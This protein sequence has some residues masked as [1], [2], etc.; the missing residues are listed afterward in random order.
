MSSKSGSSGSLA[1]RL[2]VWYTASAFA[3]VLAASGFLYWALVDNLEREDA[4]VLADQVEVLRILLRE[5]PGDLRVLKQ[6]VE[7]ETVGRQ[8]PRLLL[9]IQGPDGRVLTETPGMARELPP[10]VFPSPAEGRVA[11]R[12]AASGTSFELLAAHAE[13]YVIQVALDA[14][15]EQQLLA[16][17]R[18][19][20][21]PILAAAL[22]LSALVGH[23]IARRGIRPVEEI[24]ETARGIRS[25]TLNERIALEHLP[26]ELVS[27]AA[28][29]NGMLARLEEAFARLSRFS[30]D[31]A[32]EL[33]TP[34]N[35]L[36]GEAE[37]ALGRPR[38]PEEYREVLGSSLEE[39]A[40]LSRLIDSLLFL[41]RAEDPGTQI[42][43]ERVDLAGELSSLCAFYEA[44]AGEKGVTLKSHATEGLS[45]GLDRTLFQRAAGNLIENALAHSSSGGA[46]TLRAEREDGRVRVE[47]SDTGR[48]IAPEHLPHVFDRLYRADRSRAAATGGAGLGL[49]IVKSIAELHGGTASISSEVG[50]GTRVTLL[51]PCE[52]T[53][54]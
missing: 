22:F 36:R 35:N 46:V 20:M 34:V 30:A 10:E 54:T 21:F 44:A 42:Q 32:H 27:L 12:R 28:T 51:L 49:A 25:S 52:M 8:N 41:A 37:V 53:K 15:R 2:T 18:L 1:V 38:T 40:R 31:I 13:G 4:D 6:E 23:R 33:R 17:F 43:R 50:K 29:M 5:Y 3:I 11:G 9:R 14:T 47:V 24:S 45:A 26:S 16:D 48:G 19:R 39:C 7:V